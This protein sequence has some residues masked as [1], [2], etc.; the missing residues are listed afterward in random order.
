MVSSTPHVAFTEAG[1]R[2]S[3]PRRLV[4]EHMET[5]E[6]FCSAQQVHDELRAQGDKIG[7]A[8]VYR[9]LQGMA[10]AGEVDVLRNDDGE[11]LFRKCGDV[12]HHHLVC[13]SCGLTVEIAGPAVE[14][15]AA[16]AAEDNGFV[17]VKHSIELSG[18]CSRCASA[19]QAD[20]TD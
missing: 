6:A 8:S 5:C 3:R 4:R 16:S 17:E 10:E 7:L 13:R 18:L 19:A 20:A 2:S 12:H 9:N 14:R 11:M 1:R 15:W